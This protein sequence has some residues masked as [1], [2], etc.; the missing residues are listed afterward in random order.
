[1]N[2]EDFAFYNQIL[3]E[4]KE[5]NKDTFT[6]SEIILFN[7]IENLVTITVRRNHRAIV[8]FDLWN[9]AYTLKEKGRNLI[10]LL[11]KK[12]ADNIQTSD[13]ILS[14]TCGTFNIP[15]H[16]LKD[17]VIEFLSILTNIENL[18]QIRFEF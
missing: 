18:D 6:N 10:W 3:D 4:F 14:K 1:M 13:F 2:K 5:N 8:N 11:F 15:T 17:F 12:Y 16:N 9:I 7:K